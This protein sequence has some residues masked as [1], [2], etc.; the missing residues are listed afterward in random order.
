[1][2]D[3]K[4]VLQNWT[5]DNYWYGVLSPEG[6]VNIAQRVRSYLTMWSNIDWSKD[7]LV[8]AIKNIDWNWWTA[9]GWLTL[10]EYC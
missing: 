7:E 6:K 9:Y 2:F 1:M 5:T 10:R 3:E 8:L 4:I